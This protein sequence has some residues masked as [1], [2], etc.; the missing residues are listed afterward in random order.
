MG[1]T[2]LS[3]AL[4]NVDAEC[5][6]RGTNSVY[7]RW[8]SYKVA[9]GHGFLPVLRFS[10]VTIIPATLHT[11][12]HRRFLLDARITRH[13]THRTDL[14]GYQDSMKRARLR[15]CSVWRRVVW[16]MTTGVSGNMVPPS[17]R[18]N[19]WSGEGSRD[20]QKGYASWPLPLET[21]FFGA[22]VSLG[23]IT[24]SSARDICSFHL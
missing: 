14:C 18:E 20:A 1:L 8:I 5:L 16:Q 2:T 7:S 19:E 6:L 4:R 21:A 10:P 12:L 3:A 13:T 22:A 23:S 17:S 15:P 11:E 24:A 9:L